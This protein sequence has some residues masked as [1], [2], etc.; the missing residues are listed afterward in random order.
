MEHVAKLLKDEDLKIPKDQEIP[1][2]R[3]LIDYR[4]LAK[5]IRYRN[6]KS[7]E[8]GRHE[9]CKLMKKAFLR[10][11]KITD[12]FEVWILGINEVI[13]PEVEMKETPQDTYDKIVSRV[14]AL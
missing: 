6:T 2:M 7:K 5:A 4:K 10:F 8:E 14:F 3:I 9:I 12:D 1:V 13:F 11:H